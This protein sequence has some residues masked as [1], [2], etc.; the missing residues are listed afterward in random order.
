VKLSGAASNRGAALF[1]CDSKEEQMN[2]PNL[3]DRIRLT[4]MDD[5]P[6]PIPAG[7][8]GTVICTCDMGDY[9]HI[10]VA[11]DVQ[12]SLNLVCPPDRYEILEL[13]K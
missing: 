2:K 10:T 8:T 12:R 11:W 1:L 3:G 7:A 13:A 5:D 4:H 9:L 6:D